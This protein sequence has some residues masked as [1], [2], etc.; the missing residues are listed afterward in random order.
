MAAQLSPECRTALGIDFDPEALLA[1]YR[2]ER[3]KRL[4]ADGND[5]F[6]DI[7]EHG[8]F[9]KDPYTERKERAPL[10]GKD[11][12]S[13]VAVLG[14]GFGGMLAAVELK[15][16]GVDDFLIIEK[17]GD[18]GGTWYWNR[19]PGAACDVESYIYLPLL[20]ETNYVPIERYTHAPEILEHCENFAC[21]SRSSWGLTHLCAGARIGRTFDL[22]PKALFQTEITSLKWDGPSSRWVLETDRGDRIRARF[23]VM[24]AGPLHKPK[25]GGIE[26][27]DDFKGASFH[28]SRWDYGITGGS[29]KGNLDK[30]GDK[31]VGIIG[32]GAT[33]V[34]CIP[35]LGASAKKLYVF[36]RTPSSVDYRGNRPTDPAWA[37]KLEPGWQR[38]RM[39]NFERLVNGVAEPLDL[40][41]DGWTKLF[42]RVFPGVIRQAKEASAKFPE[43]KG[44]KHA[45]LLQLADFKQMQAVRKRVDDLVKDKETAEKLKPFYNQFCKRPCFHDEYLTTFNRPNVVLVDT[46]GKGVDKITADAVWANG[47]EYKV[48]VLIHAT[49]FEVGTDYTRR[50]GCEIYGR[51]GKT[52]TEKWKGGMESLYGLV[53]H[54]FPNLF[55]V[56]QAT[57]GAA[58]N[59]PQI[60]GEQV[61]WI[62]HVLSEG[63]RRGATEI[64]VSQKAED[65]WVAHHISVATMR[66]SF[67]RECTPGYY[68]LEGQAYKRSPKNLGYGLGM[69][70]YG[71]ILRDYIADGSMKGME[72]RGDGGVAIQAKL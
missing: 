14:G 69:L 42:S 19:Y 67:Y 28:T 72:L 1:K 45:D 53:T 31:V 47:K 10:V 55:F 41:D 2:A 64:E 36:Q 11:G 33:A 61:R 58:V 35:H 65:D 9:L 66:E 40:V 8:D 26:G 48:D 32:T 60:T 22:Y 24:S 12:E 21:C 3:D 30:L 49:G 59:F 46:N 25:L 57:V 43:L 4:R 23:V 54:D 44:L 62:V 71:E 16:K 38:R 50:T 56:Q 34:Q 20:E 13:N 29:S 27:I 7:A 63:I 68:S 15:K 37:S 5:Q 39:E 6:I 17:A 70:R 51:G 52:L 18:F